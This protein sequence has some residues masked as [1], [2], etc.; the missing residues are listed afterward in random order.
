LPRNATSDGGR[1]HKSLP[2]RVDP[3]TMHA[4]MD[5][6]I[7]PAARSMSRSIRHQQLAH[8]VIPGAAH[9]YAK[10][11][12]QY[13]LGFA[14]VIARG[15]GCRVWDLD[16][17]EYI[18]Y[19][20]GVRSITLGP[21]EPRVCQAAQD[22]LWQGTNFARPAAIEL[23]AAEMF[24]DCVPSAQ[25]VKFAK[26][27]S[28]ATTA[29]IKL[30]RA[31]TDT[32]LVAVC[33]SQPFFSVDD[34]FIG[35]VDMDAGVPAEQADLTV[36]FP[37]NDLGALETL[38]NTR[39]HD[40]ACVMLEAERDET[41]APGFLQGVRRLCD[42]H[43]CLLIVDE[44]IAGFRLAVDGGHGLHDLD[45]DLTTWGKGM[46]NGFSVSA[47]AG[48]REFMDRGGLTTDEERVF[49]LSLTHGGETHCLAAGMETMRICRDEDVPARLA[50]AGHR[51]AAGIDDAARSE[52]VFDHFHTVGHP[53]NLVFAT[54]DQHGHRSQ[55]FRTLFLQ[56]TVKR[57][58][59][60]PNLVVSAAHDDEVIDR[61]IDLVAD[62]LPMYRR[63]LENGIEPYLVG[64]CVKPV[65][66]KFN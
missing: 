17:N 38:L 60:A 57:G 22:A 40:I 7:R 34:W 9:T 42:R 41:P 31:I 44:T 51:L 29:A 30:A 1:L 61:T 21:A 12:D 58:L 18:E 2:L 49:L 6:P 14:P 45:A 46:A 50:A 54:K 15:E 35:T 59:I 19:G 53:A 23:Q 39:G 28:D 13:A 36:G 11:D 16:G 48:K 26:N 64:R 4:V 27:G 25:M 24:L 5:P 32:K 63:A 62:V 52:G 20:A 66:R 55:E 37:F 33:S 65:F 47:L 10:G 3:R 43:G 8:Q 56:E